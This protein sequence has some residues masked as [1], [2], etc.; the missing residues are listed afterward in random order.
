[1][2]LIKL[3]L[4]NFKGIKNFTLEPQGEDVSVFGDNATGKTTLIDAFMWLLTGKDSANKADFEIKTLDSDGVP[5]HYLEHSVEAILE[6]PALTL[7]R[8]YSEKWVKARG[9]SKK[10]F[11]GHETNYFLDGVPVAKKE[12]D[13]KVSS[14]CNDRIFKLISNLRYFNE[15]LKWEDRRKILLEVCGDVPD[16]KIFQS[17]LELSTLPSLIGTH[18]IDDFRKILASRRAQI[19]AELEK[20]PV[21]I[22]EV[23]RS[24]PDV[25]GMDEENVKG[26]LSISVKMKEDAEKELLTLQSGGQIAAKNQQLAEL[27][28]NAMNAFNKSIEK[29]LMRNTK[30]RANF[31]DAKTYLDDTQREIRDMTEECETIKKILAR[32]EANRTQLRQEWQTVFDGVPIISEIDTVCPYCEQPLPEEKIESARKEFEDHFKKQK[33]EKLEEINQRGKSIKLEIEKGEE[34]L[35]T[36]TASL[37]QKSEVEFP[38]IQSEFKELEEKMHGLSEIRKFTDTPEIVKLKQEIEELGKG[39]DSERYRIMQRIQS[40]KENIVVLSAQLA[41]F[42]TIRKSGVRI[43]ELKDQEKKLAEEFEKLESHLYLT[44]QFIRAKVRF[45][46]SN[47]NAKFKF[48]RFKLFD[49]QINGGISECCECII[50]GV[51]YSSNLNDGARTN[52]NLDIMNTLSDFYGF[53]MPIFID[54]AE[55]VTKYIDTNNQVIKLV[56]SEP[57]KTL[58]VERVKS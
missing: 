8:V 30:I 13:A 33:S 18:S 10:E 15:F 39:N 23:T 49:V 16:E 58:R 35:A 3:V 25:T 40:A 42:E 14:F 43:E 1:V 44:E 51:P 17:D 27:R 55:S 36:I 53:S 26:D 2:K 20:I 47:I 6:D 56:V 38:K 21:R 12:Y 24:L 34:K 22:D 28:T 29:D 41:K 31:G 4:N 52:A 32:F 50:N 7:K 5:V 46:E 45:L 19:N 9:S 57:D 11:Q 48:A 37:K 54:N